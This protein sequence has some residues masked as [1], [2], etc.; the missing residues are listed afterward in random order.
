MR[1]ILLFI[2]AMIPFGLFAQ[3]QPSVNP[4]GT[5]TTG[6]GEETDDAS[7]SMSAPVTAHFSANPSNV[8]DYSAR[9]EWKIWMEGEADKPLLHRFEEEIDY[10]F[11]Q[12][13]SYRVQ[14]YATF[15]L[16]NDTIPYPTEQDTPIIVSISQSSLDFPNAISPNGDGYNDKLRAKDGYQSIVQFEAAVFN[17]W[18]KKLFSWKELDDGWDGKHNGHVVSDGVYFLVLNAKGADGRKYHIRKAIT[19]ISGHNSQKGESSGEQQ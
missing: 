10:V 17:R 2:L 3:T 1:Q 18:G 15:I 19:V 11:T 8:G 13:G 9:Y 6:D 12:S 7:A 16:G 5:Y 14:L 4:S